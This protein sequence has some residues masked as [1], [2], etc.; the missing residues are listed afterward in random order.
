MKKIV[1]LA[2]DFLSEALNE[3]D[4]AVDLHAGRDLTHAF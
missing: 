3:T 4:T 1:D 2:H